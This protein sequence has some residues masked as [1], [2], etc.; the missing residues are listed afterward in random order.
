MACR[1][2]PGCRPESN[3]WSNLLA[4]DRARLFGN[5]VSAAEQMT[6]A[7]ARCQFIVWLLIYIV[8]LVV[9]LG[10]S[11]LGIHCTFGLQMTLLRRLFVNAVFSADILRNADADVFSNSII[12]PAIYG[13]Q[14][15][16]QHAVD[17]AEDPT[18]HSTPFIIANQA[19]LWVSMWCR[20]LE[21]AHGLRDEMGHATFG[22]GDKFSQ[23][24]S[25]R[26]SDYRGSEPKVKPPT[27]A[28]ARRR[29]AEEEE[30]EIEL[31]P[32]Q[33]AVHN[34][35]VESSGPHHDAWST[36]GILQH[37]SYNV[38]SEEASL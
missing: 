22:F 3:V 7:N 23:V 16:N 11:A 29:R 38:E 31:A 1:F 13:L 14:Y 17:I 33:A 18:L 2:R 4:T 28:S 37:R 30:D 36:D 32:R 6:S 25:Q 10:I 15:L 34:A 24:R 5:G 8:G 20:F 26:K 35:K 19:G 12:V 9:D 21:I 27:F